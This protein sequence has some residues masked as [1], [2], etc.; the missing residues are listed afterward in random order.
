MTTV[1]NGVTK[2]LNVICKNNSDICRVCA[3]EQEFIEHLFFHC[4]QKNQLWCSITNWIKLK[5]GITHVINIREVLFGYKCTDSYYEPMNLL[6]LSAKKYIFHCG[7]NYRK[8]NF[9][10]FQKL[11]KDKY[12][13]QLTL[14]KLKVTE[15]IVAK[16]WK[17]C[18]ALIQDKEL[19]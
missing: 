12:L 19:F 7:F 2:Y 5:M 6:I 9:Y 1:Q 13:D 3:T 17:L 15:Q 18:K 14:S 16:K 11:F 8:L 10:V 4:S